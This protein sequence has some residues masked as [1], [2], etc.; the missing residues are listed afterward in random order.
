M[1]RT[2]VAMSFLLIQPLCR[3]DTFEECLTLAVQ[4]A[5]P[6]TTVGELRA[7]CAA[8]LNLP[9]TMPAEQR[10]EAAVADATLASGAIEKRRA[11]EAYTHDNPFVLTPHR[12]NYLL[13]VVYENS[14][15]QEV[16]ESGAPTDQ[17]YLQNTEAQFQIS[18]KV[19]LAEKFLWDRGYLHIGYTNRAFWQVYN[20]KISAPFRENDYEPELILTFD[21]DTE[22][23]GFHNVANQFIVNHQSNGRAGEL[24]RSW[25]RLMLSTIWEKDN[26]VMSLK[27]WY[28]LPETAKSSPTDANGDDN[29][30]IER[31]LGNVEFMA[32]WERSQNVYGLMLRNNL[33]ERGDN[34]GAVELSWSYPVG[35][36]LKLYVK[37][38]NGYGESLIDYN[39]SME[40]LGI[41]ILLSDWL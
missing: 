31:F 7:L 19:L 9:V 16:F 25:N 23:F 33:H 13:P 27:P 10:E 6:A 18:L 41:G 36:K 37:Y 14:P 3:A 35:D 28:R 39:Q 11:L 15:N 4:S 20:R 22:W 29:P 8:R 34:K 21:N 32:T 40:S 38:F 1:R 17:Q 30:D 12:P 5:T 2:V 24:S 26:F